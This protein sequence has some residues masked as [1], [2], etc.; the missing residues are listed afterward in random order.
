[1]TARKTNP[2]VPGVPF[3]DP[4]HPWRANTEHS[5][6]AGLKAKARSPWSRGPMVT[7]RNALA[8]Q[9]SLKAKP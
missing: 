6:K 7:T 5:R 8:A 4:L 3:G 9:A 2:A 1:M